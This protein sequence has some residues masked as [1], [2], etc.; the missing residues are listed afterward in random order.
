MKIQLII[1]ALSIMALAGG[2]V[3]YKARGIRNNNPGNIRHGSQWQGMT[4]TQTDR[5]FVQFTDS[6][7]GI[8]ALNKVLRTYATRYGLTSVRGIINRW[9]PPNENDTSSYV[10]SVAA[11]LGVLPDQ[12]IDVQAYAPELT[13]AIIKHENGVQPYSDQTIEQGIRLGWA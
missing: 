8:R 10:V 9:A 13:R 1:A 5:A 3:V 4:E 12:S 11:R 7:Y 6:V 2:V